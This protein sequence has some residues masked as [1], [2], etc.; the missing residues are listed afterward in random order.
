M[1]ADNGL[2]RVVRSW[3]R[4]DRHE[5]A[6]NILFAVLGDLDTTPQRRAG[7]L[8][9]RFPLMNSTTM[10]Y[11]L[12]AAAVV[13]VTLVG[14][15]LLPGGIGGPGPGPTPISTPTPPVATPDAGHSGTPIPSGLPMLTEGTQL[16]G[17]TYL[18][19]D[20]F[21]I[22]AAVT[23]PEGWF[24]T[25]LT[26]SFALLT[27]DADVP[28]Q[29]VRPAL[30][31]WLVDFIPES[32]PVVGADPTPQPTHGPAAG[33]IAA[34][35]AGRPGFAEIEMTPVT[36]DGFG[37]VEMELRPAL[38]GLRCTSGHVRSYRA[39]PITRQ[40]YPGDVSRI[41]ILEV[42]GQVLLVDRL[43]WSENSEDATSPQALEELEAVYRS[44]NFAP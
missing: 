12:A 41:T 38:G 26:S 25:D 13:L 16:E 18:L 29:A 1:R 2:E 22:T 19:G 24:V 21:P 17:G 6:E 4:E 5:D 15:N 27:A 3:L 32:C 33:D 36:L 42:D 23:V 31:F 7:W 39:G 9:R 30:A 14:I 37:G 20:P 11:G 35:I 44:I 8:A 34:A 40:Q 10:R 28:D 43:Y